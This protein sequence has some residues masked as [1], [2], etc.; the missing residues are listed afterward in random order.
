MRLVHLQ[1]TPLAWAAK[2]GQL[3]MVQFLLD[4]RGAAPLSVTETAWRE[5][6]A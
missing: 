2:C 3:E 5:A 1:C 4:R 6:R